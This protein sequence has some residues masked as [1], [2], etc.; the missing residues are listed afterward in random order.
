M[1]IALC[2]AASPSI[3]CRKVTLLSSLLERSSQHSHTM[4]VTASL[5]I[6]AA[7][8]ASVLL[9][10][11]LS[12]PSHTFALIVFSLEV[13]PLWVAPNLDCSCVVHEQI[14]SPRNQLL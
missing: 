7:S 14:M 9:A 6:G 5:S 4:S 11:R 12:D 3:C 10:S 2:Y 1:S 8:F 13:R